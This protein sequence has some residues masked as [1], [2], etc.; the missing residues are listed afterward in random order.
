MRRLA[1]KHIIILLLLIAIALVLTRLEVFG[2]RINTVGYPIIW[3][4]TGVLIYK[5]FQYLRGSG[6]AIR[7]SILGLA[8]AAYVFGSLFLGLQFL[9]CGERQAGTKYMSREEDGLF[10][11]CRIDDC[12]ETIIPCQFTKVRTLMGGI[13]WVTK[14]ER[15]QVDLTKWKAMRDHAN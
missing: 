6:S 13:S 1:L 10:L 11:E 2:F 7:R 14:L 4:A 3:I 5:I 8:L 15:K 9:M 12:S